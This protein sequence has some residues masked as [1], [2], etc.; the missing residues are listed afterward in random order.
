MNP[1]EGMQYNASIKEVKCEKEN[2]PNSLTLA[3]HNH[4]RYIRDLPLSGGFRTIGFGQNTKFTGDR[5][6]CQ[7]MKVFARVVKSIN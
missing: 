5:T 2:S 6:L 1:K 3:H 4:L 7:D